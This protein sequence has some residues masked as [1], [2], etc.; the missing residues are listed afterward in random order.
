LKSLVQQ[1][2]GNGSIGSKEAMKISKATGASAA[3]VGYAAN[4]SNIGLGAKFANQLGTGPMRNMS[5]NQYAGMLADSNQGLS[6]FL[7]GIQGVQLDKGQVYMGSTKTV[8]PGVA[9][10]KWNGGP[11][12]ST[13]SYTP[14]VGMKNMTI[15]GMK[16]NDA[17]GGGK[18]GKGGKGKNKPGGSLE[19]GGQDAEWRGGYKNQTKEEILA[20]YGGM[21]TDAAAAETDTTAEPTDPAEEQTTDTTSTMPT[22]GSMAGGGAGPGGA[23]GLRRRSGRLERLGIRRQGTGGL[24]RTNKFFSQ[25]N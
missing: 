14:I 10:N 19:V 22:I 6:N 2:G 5:V 21:N 9:G 13:T 23:T 8:T 11:T 16:Q 20:E 4:Q 24:N 18:G 1:Y 15:G 7:S 17:G 3:Q 25:I 12:N